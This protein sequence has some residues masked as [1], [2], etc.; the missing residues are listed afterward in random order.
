MRRVQFARGSVGGFRGQGGGPGRLRQGHGRQFQ[1]LG[2]QI[3]A[4]RRPVEGADAYLVGDAARVAPGCTV[5]DDRLARR[6]T[7]GE[8]LEEVGLQ[9]Q[10]RP[11][12]GI[13]QADHRVLLVHARLEGVRSL[14]LAGVPRQEQR[15]ALQAPGGRGAAVRRASGWRCAGTRPRAGRRRRAGSVRRQRDGVRRRRAGKA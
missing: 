12:R 1:P 5:P 11:Q 7:R 9:P 15:G 2:S 10:F 13:R 6:L 14:R 3:Q 8:S 4:A